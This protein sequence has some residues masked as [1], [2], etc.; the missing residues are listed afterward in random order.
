MTKGNR[1]SDQMLLEQFL[2]GDISAYERLVARYE[3][4]VFN[5]IRRIIGRSQE[6]E[7]L[8]Q[9]TFIRVY[10]QAQTL[11]ERPAFRSWLW[12][13]AANLCRDHLRRQSY[14]DHLPLD[15]EVHT[16]QYPGSLNAPDR[17]LE[18]REVG[19]IIDQAIDALKTDQRI[20]VVLREYHGL[21]YQEI[22]EIVGCSTTTVKS[23][24]HTARQELRNRLAFLLDT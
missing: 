6:A 13:I 8:A 5:F 20:V 24:L 23:R 10:E 12:S 22:A 7:D 15:L 21:S 9:E 19:Q 14:R 18:E 1:Q 3:K 11:N 2:G 4:P 16:V 17:N